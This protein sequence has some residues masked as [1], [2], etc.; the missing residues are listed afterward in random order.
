[1]TCITTPGHGIVTD[2]L[3]MHGIVKLF[4][5]D[6]VRRIGDRYEICGDFSKMGEIV[7]IIREELEEYSRNSN[8]ARY[9]IYLGK[10]LDSNINV[11]VTDS[12]LKSFAESLNEIKDV[13]KAYTEDHKVRYKEGR[14]KSK[15]L[16]NLYLPLGFIYGKYTVDN[17]DAVTKEY[18]VCGKCFSLSNLGLIFGTAIIRYI[19][20]NNADVTLISL[21]PEDEME[22]DELLLIERFVE[23]K[24]E[25][26]NIELTLKSVLVYALFF[27]E[28]IYSFDSK[29]DALVWR[30]EKSGN[31][32]RALQPEIFDITSLLDKIARLKSMSPDYTKILTLLV[33]K[34]Y[35]DQSI[36]DDL[37]EFLLFGGDYYRVIREITFFINRINRLNDKVTKGIDLE[38]FATT[39]I[40]LGK[41]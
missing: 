9:S 19:S 1:M 21:I 20:G 14:S 38:K 41:D 8:V 2:T 33:N 5:V 30:L 12:W 40:E 7:E 24:S 17:Y 13:E 22:R 36:L 10:I 29:V 35:G 34:D 37:A 28:T 11:S 25:N 6:K 4:H 27:G 16:Y 15:A 18:R 26:I 3:I 31:F 32:Q 23:G 39:F